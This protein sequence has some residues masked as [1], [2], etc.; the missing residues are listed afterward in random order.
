MT[1][2]LFNLPRIKSRVWN[3][4]VSVDSDG[5]YGEQRHGYQ[6]VSGEREHPAEGA[7]VRPRALP[8]GGSSQRQVEAA[9]QQVRA[10][11]VHYEHGRCIANLKFK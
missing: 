7:A 3:H 9:K 4:D 11:Q 8:E 10:G 6:R 1:I 5:Q 2:Y